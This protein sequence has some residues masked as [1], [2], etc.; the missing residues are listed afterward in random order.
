MTILCLSLSALC[1]ASVWAYIK[2][3]RDIRRDSKLPNRMRLENQ[4][5]Q[6]R[7]QTDLSSLSDAYWDT[8]TWRTYQAWELVRRNRRK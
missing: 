2:I 3:T 6:K 8:D 4:G 5:L 1:F 7:T